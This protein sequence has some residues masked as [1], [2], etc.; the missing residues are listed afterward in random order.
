MVV[1]VMAGAGQGKPPDTPSWHPGLPH[2][3]C[4]AHG[5]LGRPWTSRQ[6]PRPRSAL[7]HRPQPRSP[8]ED[9]TSTPGSHPAGC[10]C[11]RPG[12]GLHAACRPPSGPGLPDPDPCASERLAWPQ[13]LWL[14]CLPRHLVQGRRRA[15]V[16]WHRSS[17]A[18]D[19]P[20]CTVSCRVRAVVHTFRATP[21]SLPA[22]PASPAQ[23]D[24][25]VTHPPSPRARERKS[26]VTSAL[27]PSWSSTGPEAWVCCSES[28]IQVQ[29]LPRQLR[30]LQQ[31]S[32]PLWACLASVSR[33]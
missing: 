13:R 24:P 21:P 20:K 25:G 12:F 10:G 33:G 29:L 32:W 19:L 26:S 17:W 18:T 9:P 5:P 6:S 15:P 31:A 3:R 16:S 22:S 27:N 2:P 30:D 23:L 4:P 14:G 7:V 28:L 11:K 1:R 8:F